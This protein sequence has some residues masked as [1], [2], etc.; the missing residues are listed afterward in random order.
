LVGQE[1]ATCHC[2][3]ST[4]ERAGTLESDGIR[5]APHEFIGFEVVPALQSDDEIG[6][7]EL[8]EKQID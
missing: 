6:R 1:T 4:N 7:D 5:Y 2:S 3:F 8:N